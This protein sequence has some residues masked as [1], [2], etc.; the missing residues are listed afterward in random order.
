MSLHGRVIGSGFAGREMSLAEGV[1]C[2]A[3]GKPGR[4]RN[5]E[6]FWGGRKWGVVWRGPENQGRK[7]EI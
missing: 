3:A 2:A 4:L 7:E 5:P 6:M 1:A